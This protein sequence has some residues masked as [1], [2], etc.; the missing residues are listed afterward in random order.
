MEKMDGASAALQ[1][2]ALLTYL[3]FLAQRRVGDQSGTGS[4]APA[5]RL[6]RREYDRALSLAECAAVCRMSES[7]FRHVFREI[8]GMPPHRYQIK[9]RMEHAQWL[10]ENT[11][12]GAE[13]ISYTVGYRDFSAFYRAY[14]NAYGRSPGDERRK[15]LYGS[16]ERS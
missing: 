11:S 13:Q 1:N 8:M 2:G 6:M 5:L 4:V 15:F 7:R 10:L 16:V 9:L 3:G 14:R 12:L